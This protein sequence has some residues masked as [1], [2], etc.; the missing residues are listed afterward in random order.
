MGGAL[1]LGMSGCDSKDIVRT[2]ETIFASTQNTSFV[3]IEGD[4][5]ADIFL[6]RDG[7]YDIYL[8]REGC[9]IETFDDAEGRVYTLH[10]DVRDMTLA[11]EKEGDRRIMYNKRQR[12]K[13]SKPSNSML[14]DLD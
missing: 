6:R 1:V 9:K 13:R 3:D 12:E 5:K 4:G 7:G 8:R 10:K 2:P 11:E 14:Y